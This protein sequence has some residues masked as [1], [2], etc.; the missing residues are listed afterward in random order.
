MFIFFISFKSGNINL[1][2]LFGKGES[3]RFEYTYGN[4]RA[5]WKGGV[6]VMFIY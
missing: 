3:G 2:N 1:P 5:S 6:L 4:Y